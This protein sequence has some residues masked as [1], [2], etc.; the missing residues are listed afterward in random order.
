M[1]DHDCERGKVTQR[2]PIPYGQFR[3]KP[4]VTEPNG[5]K[6]KLPGGN[7][8]Q[9]NLMSNAGSAETYLKWIQVF[10][11]VLDQ[12]KLHESSVPLPSPLR[13]LSKS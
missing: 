5:I 3:Y 11:C 6:I 12:K 10:I 7:Q 4:W 13:R 8:F 9:C 1:K 2:P